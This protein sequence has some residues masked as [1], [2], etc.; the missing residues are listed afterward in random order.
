[1]QSLDGLNERQRRAVETDDGPVLIVAG[2]GTGKTKT[3]AARIAY[4]ID[5]E[6]VA[7]SEI[8]ALTFTN[9]AGAGDARAV[10]REFA[11]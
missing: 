1:M 3:L 7:P 5:N 6:K 11:K 9:K 10:G 8:V 2:P 4:L